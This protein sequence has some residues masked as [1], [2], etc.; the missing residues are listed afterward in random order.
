MLRSNPALLKMLADIMGSAPRL[1]R[2]L[3]RRPRV[4]DAVLDPGFMGELPSEAELAELR[5]EQ[6]E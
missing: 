2:I 5:L 1:A 4:V 3:S 6:A